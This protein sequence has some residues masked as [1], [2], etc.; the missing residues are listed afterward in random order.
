MLRGTILGLHGI[1]LYPTSHS[2][3]L[4]SE[5]PPSRAMGTKVLFLLQP[6][7]WWLCCFTDAI[8]TSHP[9]HQCAWSPFSYV[10]NE[11][12]G[13]R[14]NSSLLKL[15]IFPFCLHVHVYI[16]FTIYILN[17]YNDITTSDKSYSLTVCVICCNIKLSKNFI[18]NL[19]QNEIYCEI[20]AQL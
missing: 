3:C 9:F 15:N 12:N 6:A 16:S 13:S 5:G 18:C 11:N 7:P 19:Y 20:D 8:P 14:H 4:T 2:R 17:M 1:C 10:Q